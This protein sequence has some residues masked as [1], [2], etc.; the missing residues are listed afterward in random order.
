MFFSKIH[1]A[2]NESIRAIPE[3]LPFFLDVTFKLFQHFS[4]LFETKYQMSWCIEQEKYPNCVRLYT[5]VSFE[6]LLWR[7]FVNEALL[8]WQTEIRRTHCKYLC[9][10]IFLSWPTFDVRRTLVE[11][12]D[13]SFIVVVVRQQ[14][15]VLLP[16]R[17][18]VPSAACILQP[19]QHLP[20]AVF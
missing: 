15:L 14:L 17:N 3:N 8:S 2:Q 4:G 18:A 12:D 7:E 10:S 9:S 11:G 6:K 1:P 16:L 19:Y 13:I 5:E 20:E